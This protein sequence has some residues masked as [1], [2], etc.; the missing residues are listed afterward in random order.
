[1]HVMDLGDII[2]RLGSIFVTPIAF[3]NNS[4]TKKEKDGTWGLVWG[5]DYFSA[6]SY[7]MKSKQAFSYMK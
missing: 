6:R 4:F 7:E 1:M 2:P 5:I 3:G